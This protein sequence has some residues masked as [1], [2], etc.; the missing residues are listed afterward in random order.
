[1]DSPMSKNAP[2]R[3]RNFPSAEDEAKA[4]QPHGRYDGPG[5]SFRMAFTDTEFLL[6]DELRPAPLLLRDEGLEQ[7]G[8]Q[9]QT[10]NIRQGQPDRGPPRLADWT[11]RRDGRHRPHGRLG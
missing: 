11:A 7:I 8:N 9:Q 4:A 10:H 1:M 5:S 3:A 6:R 2:L